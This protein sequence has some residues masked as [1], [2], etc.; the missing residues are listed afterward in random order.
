MKKIFDET[1]WLEASGAQW[2][3]SLYASYLEDPESVDPGWRQ[4]FDNLDSMEPFSV[5]ASHG[6]STRSV[7]SLELEQLAAKQH[8]VKQL[9]TAYRRVGYRVALLDPLGRQSM[10]VMEDLTL[11]HY[12]LSE[13]DLDKSFHPGS[14]EGRRCASLS[15]SSSTPTAVPSGRS[16]C[17]L[18]TPGSV[19][20]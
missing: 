11:D 14:L 17:T 13:A 4:K 15:R 19:S 12:G 7:S 9:I 6:A 5:P 1:S 10:P 16:I 20:G 18:R 3:E 2:L 8:G